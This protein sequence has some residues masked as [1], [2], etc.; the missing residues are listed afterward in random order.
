M[1]ESKIIYLEEEMLDY[2]LKSRT[3]N[4]DFLEEAIMGRKV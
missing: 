3:E 4:N 1:Q 2:I